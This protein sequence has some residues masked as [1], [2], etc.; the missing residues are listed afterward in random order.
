MNLPFRGYT[1][2]HIANGIKMFI[3]AKKYKCPMQQKECPIGQKR[4]PRRMQLFKRMFGKLEQ[5]FEGRGDKYVIPYDDLHPLLQKKIDVL[6][7]GRNVRRWWSTLFL[8]IPPALLTVNPNI[9][10]ATALYLPFA[11]MGELCVRS[12]TRKI[13]K[14]FTDSPNKIISD[15]ALANHPHLEDLKKRFTHLFVRGNGDI[16]FTR[17][18]KAGEIIGLVGRMHIPIHR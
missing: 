12:G 17:E 16:V 6:I 5:K 4:E 9:A 8:I 7:E 11:E 3:N 2:A 10:V 13:G 14:Y 1:T 15:E 18:K